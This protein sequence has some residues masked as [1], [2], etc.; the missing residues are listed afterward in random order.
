MRIS[1]IGRMLS[2]DSTFPSRATLGT[3]AAMTASA[4]ELDPRT[5]RP[6]KR[7]RLL[8]DRELER[9]IT[10]AALSTR[11]LR[12]YELLLA[13]RRRRAALG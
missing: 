4:Y 9:E 6:L 5:G 13:E 2:V 8:T 3:I 1:A 12:R 10:I 11:R 7:T